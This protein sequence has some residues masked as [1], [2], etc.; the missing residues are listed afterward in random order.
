MLKKERADACGTFEGMDSMILISSKNII[1]FRL[2]GVC[3]EKLRPLNA[4]FSR[5]GSD[6]SPWQPCHSLLSASNRG[7][8]VSVRVVR[9][10]VFLDTWL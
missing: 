6:R 5:T 8:P 9:A 1:A 2:V 3:R 10:S 7:F 4:L